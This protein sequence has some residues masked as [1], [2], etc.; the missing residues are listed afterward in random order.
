MEKYAGRIVSLHMKDLDKNKE[1]A[2][3]GE[4]VIDMKKVIKTARQIG[5]QWYIVEQDNTRKGKEIMDEIAISYKNL[6]ALL[7]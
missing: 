2:P 1:L 4:G 6:A 7:S 3:V 5:V